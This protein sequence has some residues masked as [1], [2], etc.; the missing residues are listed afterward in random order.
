MCWHTVA[1]LSVATSGA[2]AAAAGRWT[3][4]VAVRLQ[5]TLHP[6]V[7]A[8][9][10][11]INIA[12]NGAQPVACKVSIS[13]SRR[14]QVSRRRSPHMAPGLLI[15]SNRLSDSLELLDHVRSLHHQLP[16]PPVGRPRFVCPSL[17]LPCTRPARLVA[18]LKCGPVQSQRRGA[19]LSSACRV[20]WRLAR[21]PP[22]ALPRPSRPCTRCGVP[23]TALAAANR[24]NLSWRHTACLPSTTGA[25]Q[26]RCCEAVRVRGYL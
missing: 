24:D 14:S 5:T 16:E 2:P 11:K 4:P 6:A 3:L 13:A 18:S 20:S 25:A 9:N 17:G 8:S 7:H 10:P 21:W 12:S 19:R 26:C 23:H 15:A 1:T 22:H